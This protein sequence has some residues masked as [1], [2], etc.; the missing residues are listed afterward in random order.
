MRSL[1]RWDPSGSIAAIGRLEPHTDRRERRASHA[2]H[3]RERTRTVFSERLSAFDFSAPAR[4]LHEAWLGP[5]QP[6]RFSVWSKCHFSPGRIRSR[7]RAQG[8]WP[9]ATIGAQRLR[10][11]WWRCPRPLAVVEPLYLDTAHPGAL[12]A[13]HLSP[14]FHLVVVR[15]LRVELAENIA[16][17]LRD[18]SLGVG[19]RGLEL[20][21]EKLCGRS[22]RLLCPAQC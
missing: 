12:L 20:G 10:S 2:H 6:R 14:L 17:L 21:G 18:P 5:S 1:S 19:R 3:S 9:V 13:A 11:T 22:Q 15:D 16:Q 8:T 4:S 7:Q